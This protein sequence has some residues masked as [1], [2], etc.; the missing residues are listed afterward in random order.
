MTVREQEVLEYII[1][2]KQTNGY[3]PTA[4]EIMQGVNT[5]SK[6]YVDVALNHLVDE[7]YITLK[8]KSPRTIRVL[9]FIS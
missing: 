1:K 3:S 5:K 9:K 7:G 4:Q 6:N 2:F 8:P